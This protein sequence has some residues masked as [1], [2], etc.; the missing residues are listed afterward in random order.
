MYMFKNSTNLWQNWPDGE[1]YDFSIGSWAPCGASWLGFW[2][3]QQSWFQCTSPDILDVDTLTCVPS[4]DSSQIE[5]SDTT[6]F[7]VDS[8][9]R[10]LE[11]YIDPTSE[12]LLE[13]GTKQYPYRTTKPVFAEIL[14]HHSHTDREIKVYLKEGTNTYIEDSSIFIINLE[15]LT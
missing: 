13:F 2:G 12:E 1:Y 15:S 8:I 4:C 5:I 10:T 7:G 3:A 9:W 14:K 6:L 11:Y